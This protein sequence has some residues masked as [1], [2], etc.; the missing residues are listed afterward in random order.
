MEIEVPQFAI[1]A[2]QIE[3]GNP[4]SDVILSLV[5]TTSGSMARYFLCE[6]SQNYQ[7]IAKQLH[8][9]INQA[10]SAARRSKSKIVTVQALP[11]GLRNGHGKV[12]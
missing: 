12:R 8:D 7:D 5:V 1:E 6:A 11:D 9:K 2:A 3:P 4:D 10:G